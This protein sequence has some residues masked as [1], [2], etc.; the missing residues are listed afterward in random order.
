M[1]ETTEVLA[2]S[3][4]AHRPEPR[5]LS[6]PSRREALWGY[7]FIGPWLIGLVAASR[8]AR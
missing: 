2:V 8:P 6:T 1:T 3:V 7:V 4:T 5:W